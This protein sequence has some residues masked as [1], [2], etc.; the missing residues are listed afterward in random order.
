MQAEGVPTLSAE[1]QL[2]AVVQI[3][4]QRAVQDGSEGVP[5]STSPA[6]VDTIPSI[7]VN[8]LQTAQNPALASVE[9][10][11]FAPTRHHLGPLCKRGHAWGSTG[12]S[13]RNADNQ[14]LVCRAQAKREKD[15]A[16]KAE[17][18]AQLA[19]A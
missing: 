18:E 15:A 5:R 14:C 10:P 9:R 17:Q 6:S 7:Q 12:Q 16:K 3:L 2:Q 1:A 8:A 19:S 11:T 13:L 4:E